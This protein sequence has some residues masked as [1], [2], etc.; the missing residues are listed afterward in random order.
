VSPNR[1]K[2][3]QTLRYAVR[4][5]LTVLERRRPRDSVRQACQARARH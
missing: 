1:S 3:E 2:K 4:Q 5:R